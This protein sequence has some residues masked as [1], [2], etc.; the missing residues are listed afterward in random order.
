MRYFRVRNFEK[1]QHYKDRNP[2]WIK[3]YY[4]LLR[5]YYFRK[6]K[7]SARF[8]YIAI[9]LLASRT[10]NKIIWDEADLKETLYFTSKVD[11]DEMK[12]LD[13]I[14]EIDSDSE[15]LAPCYQDAIPEKSR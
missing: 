8:H 9:G 15:L 2:P 13:L 4:D 11:L 10:T 3:L 6:L 14:E 5:D 1:F 7:D 12:A